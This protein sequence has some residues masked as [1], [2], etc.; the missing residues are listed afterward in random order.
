MSVSNNPRCGFW[1]MVDFVI[2]KEMWCN[3]IFKK[4][5][6]LTWRK[7]HNRVFCVLLWCRKAASAS[8][9]TRSKYTPHFLCDIMLN[10]CLFQVQYDTLINYSLIANFCFVVALIHFFLTGENSSLRLFSCLADHLLS[11]NSN[12]MCKQGLYG[13]L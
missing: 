8:L 1:W 3:V 6:S 4:K 11:D 5:G 13:R 10:T 12:C 7:S 9:Y 2:N